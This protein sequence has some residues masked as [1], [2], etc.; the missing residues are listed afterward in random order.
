MEGMKCHNETPCVA[1]LNIQKCLF[2]K[3]KV[4]KSKNRSCLGVGTSGKGEDTR[5]EHRRANIVEVLCSNV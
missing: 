2:S 1:I 5:K 3:M 4:R